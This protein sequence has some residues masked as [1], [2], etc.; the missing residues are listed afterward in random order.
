MYHAVQNGDYYIALQ[1]MPMGSVN[2]SGVGRE[3]K[4]NMSGGLYISAGI[5]WPF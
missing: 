3:G 4:L 1:Y 5:Y 2:F